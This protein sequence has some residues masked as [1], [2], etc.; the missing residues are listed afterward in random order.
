VQV[1]EYHC[2]ACAG[3]PPQPERFRKPSIAIVRSGNFGIRSEHGSQLLSSGFLL[4]GTPGQAYEAFHEHDGGD[5]CLVFEFKEQAFDQLADSLQRGSRRRPFAK[6]VLPPHPRLEALRCLGEEQLFSGA[7]NLGMEELSLVLASE[8]LK[9]VG[10]GALRPQPAGRDSARARDCIH[11][12]MELLERSGSQAPG[13]EE[14]AHSV[15]L[16]AFHFLRLF[17]RETG[18]TPYQ[19]LIKLRVR[20]AIELLRDTSRPVTDIAYDVGFGDLSNF[21]NAFRREVGCSPRR[22]RSARS[23]D[24]LRDFTA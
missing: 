20:R 6:T 11:A 18:V 7:P 17:K 15:G 4:L 8:V 5:R 22:F 13:L 3:D 12:A 14:L 1:R 9:L 23:P 24:W 19:F 10:R 21:I 16:S 2:T